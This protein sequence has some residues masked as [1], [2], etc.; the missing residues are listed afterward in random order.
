MGLVAWGQALTLTCMRAGSRDPHCT[1]RRDRTSAGAGSRARCAAEERRTR[2]RAAPPSDRSLGLWLVLA[3][4]LGLALSLRHWASSSGFAGGLCVVD[5]PDHD[6]TRIFEGVGEEYSVASSLL[7]DGRRQPRRPALRPI[8]GGVHG[9][10]G[11]WPPKPMGPAAMAVHKAP[12]NRDPQPAIEPVCFDGE[13]G[14]GHRTEET[15][16]YQ[17][18]Q[19]LFIGHHH[20]E[21]HQIERPV[22]DLPGSN[23]SSM[24]SRR[25]TR[26]VVDEIHSARGEQPIERLLS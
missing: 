2:S 21:M 3:L 18:G 12:P 16:P 13:A 4:S 24:T 1:C 7:L 11:P 19:R 23:I 22:P 6:G 14:A 15:L 26:T 9:A 25:K 10:A 17:R 8:Q 20:V 5:V